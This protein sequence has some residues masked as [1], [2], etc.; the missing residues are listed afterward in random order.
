VEQRPTPAATPESAENKAATAQRLL[1]ALKEARTKLEAFERATYEPLAVVGIGCRFP[2]GSDSPDQFWH[3]L[4]EGVDAITTVPRDRWDMDAYYDA[5]PDAPGKIYTKYGAFLGPVDGFDPAFFGIAPREVPNLDPQQRLLLEVSWEALEHGN[6][7]PATLFDSET[8]VFVGISGNS[9]AN[10]LADADPDSHSDTYFS[11]GNALSVSAG[12][13]SYVL[14]LTGPCLAV[15]TACSSSL[16]AVHLACQSLRRHEC[17][18]AL[19]GGVNLMLTPHLSVAFA[20]GRF[21]AP[22][23]RC[24]T[25]SAAANGYGRGEGCGVIVLKRLADAVADGDKILALIR[26]TAINHDGRSSGLTAPSGVSQQKVIRQALADGRVDPAQVGYVEAHGTGTALGDP[27]EV[28]ALGEVFANATEPVILGSAK[29]NMG[30]LEAAA[31]IA[32]LIKVV[33]S[34]QHAQIPPNLHFQEPNPHIDWANLPVTVPTTLTDWPAA[35]PC[36]GVSSFGFSGTNAHVVVEKAPTTTLTPGAAIN[37]AHADRETA[38]TDLANERPQHLLTLSAKTEAALTA[39]AHRYVDFFATQDDVALGDLCYSAYTG[40]NHFEHRLSVVGYSVADLRQKLATHLAGESN[41]SVQQGK[42]QP[43]GRPKIAF[44][45]TGQGSQYV[46]MGRELYATEPRFRQILERC[47]AVFQQQMGRSLLELLYPATPPSHN[48]LMDSHPC[49][50]A[51]NFALECA[52]ADLWRAWGIHPDVVLGHSL[53]DFAAA[54][55]AGVLTLEEGLALVTARGRFMATADGEMVAVMAGEAAVAPFLRDCPDVAIGVINGPHSV[56]ISGGR[57]NVARITEQLRLAGFKT[58]KLAIPVAAHSPILD[59]VLAEFEAVVRRVVLRPPQVPVVSSM[60]GA[61][62]TTELTDPTYW[63]RHL[64]NPVRFADG[65]TTL[66]AHGV[67]LLIEIGPKPT[68]LGMVEQ[69]LEPQ[70]TASAAPVML[71]PSLRDNRSDWQQMVESLGGLY[72]QGAALDWAGF[73]QARQRQKVHL[74]TYP[75]QR[76]RYWVALPT[77]QQPHRQPGE[78]WR[79]WL[80]TVT[81]PS[82]PIFGTRPTFLPDLGALQTHL[83]ARL[84]TMTDEQAT[85]AAQQPALQAL[86]ELVITYILAAFAKAGFT[87]TAGA[88]WRTEQ[89]GQR[90]G[91]IPQQQRLLRRLLGMLTEV[92]LLRRGADDSWQVQATAA[93]QRVNGTQPLRLL[94]ADDSNAVEQAL[95]QRCGAQLGE[96]LRGL[97]EPVELLFPAG[98]ASL[99]TRLYTDTPAAALLNRLVQATLQSLLA[100]LPAGRGLRIL[101]VGAGTGSTTAWLLPLLPATRIEYHFTDLSSAFLSKARAEFA[102]YPFIH[103]QPLDIEQAPDAQGFSLQHYDLVI[104]ANVLH[105]TQEL[106]TSLRH[107]RQLLAPGG[108]LLLVEGVVRKHWIDLIF[109]LTEGWWRFADE[110]TEHPLLPTAAWQ[111]LLAEGGF[112]ST[113]LPGDSDLERQLGQALI[114]A[115]PTENGCVSAELGAL[116]TSRPSELGVSELGALATSRPSELGASELGALATSRLVANAPSSDRVSNSQYRLAQRQAWLLFADSRGVAR[117]LAAELT[118]RGDSVTLVQAGATYARL[119]EQSFTIRPTVAADYQSLV[120]ATPARQAIIH[121]WSLDADPASAALVDLASVQ[122][123]CGT[124]LLL[125]QA[126]ITEQ[127]ALNGLWLVTSGAQALAPSVAPGVA[128]GALAPGVLHATLWGL[129]RVISQENPE[130]KPTLV[131]LDPAMSVTEQA[132]LLAAEVTTPCPGEQV[133]LRATG[134]HTARFTRYAAQPAAPLTVRG[135]ATYLITGGLGGLGLATARWLVEQGARHLLLLGRSEPK[136]AALP[137][138][139]AMRALGATV[140]TVQADVTDRAQV[141][142]LLAAINPRRPLRGLI[143]AVG[144]LDDGALA[145]QNWR[146]FANVL[147]PKVLGAWHLH[148]LTHPDN[149]LMPGGALDF[150]VLFSSAAG[151][152][153]NQGQANHAAANAFLD[154]LAAQRHAQGLPAL[155]LDWGAWSEVGSAAD[156]VRHH[157]E[158]LATHG[159]DAIAP[160]DGLAALTA[161]SGQPIAQAA[162]IPMNWAHF[163]QHERHDQPFFAQLKATLSA[164]AAEETVTAPAESTAT[165]TFRQSLEQTPPAEQPQRLLHHLRTIA[166]T[167]LGM[168]TPAQLETRRG[169]MEMGLDSLMAVELRNRVAKSLEV[170][171]PSTLLFD[172]PTLEELNRYLYTDV[173]Q[174]AP[175]VQPA[176]QP[177]PAATGPT[178]GQVQDVQQLSPQALLDFIAGKFKETSTVSS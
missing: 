35:R 163:F 87:L 133:A 165:L 92:G 152:L 50:Q 147:A 84:A 121:L 118:Q 78:H 90:L 139:A 93:S 22:D 51:A 34:L 77:N 8:G 153:G 62:V 11:T 150:F 47:D 28:W 59:P 117:A 53:G 115:R 66:A 155:C 114:L 2:G 137:E 142:R 101:E 73:D 7:P 166:A 159:Q 6:L 98:D 61:L 157:R 161:L 40:R 148:T 175:P 171:L 127:R 156:F 113:A 99:I 162:V 146:R 75:F 141:A 116:A 119:D 30:H 5:D 96:V 136:A 167:V 106:R 38:A 134:R 135:D 172:Y 138:L 129:G 74:P 105:A 45:F 124:V 125:T 9:Y 131:D 81:W 58:R 91:V 97:Q 69:I 37:G 111:R 13:L 151:L 70:H 144:V 18:L 154:A 67:R 177:A 120:A 64:R 24:K 168:P 132:A 104:A 76:Q 31:G 145:N 100:A 57:V 94:P 102:A 10:L 25:F 26:G 71:L 14:G 123:S 65:V 52:L 164:S 19:A 88:Q 110:R 56:V 130:L 176:P 1:L 49:G 170:S 85:V 43:S 68:L 109:G 55:T 86:D 112:Q 82:T 140:T 122:Q 29:S 17:K 3:L 16:V 21:L 80:Y 72:V 41:V 83:L 174:L 32:G 95:V 44:L 33:L 178:P 103:Y 39:L 46:G 15:D 12:R 107:V 160:R 60:T 20:K 149:D 108:L 36:A 128:P 4:Q 48:D 23:G 143:H 158:Q 42:S 54:Y 169:L 63:R 79:D 126:L 27:I 89:I 173:L